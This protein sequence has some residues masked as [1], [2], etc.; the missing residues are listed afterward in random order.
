M[1]TKIPDGLTVRVT[2]NVREK[3]TRIVIYRKGEFKRA[4]K[5]IIPM[6]DHPLCKGLSPHDK[7]IGIWG[8][9]KYKVY[10]TYHSRDVDN[11]LKRLVKS[12]C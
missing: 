1:P 7:V 4:Y 9:T 12:Y 2:T 5:A 10:T 3:T 8:S 6:C 11:L